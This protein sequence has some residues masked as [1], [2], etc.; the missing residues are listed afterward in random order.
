MP[1]PATYSAIAATFA[2]LSAG[3]NAYIGF[4]N[5]QDALDKQILDRLLKK[6]D[7]CNQLILKNGHRIPYKD[8]EMGDASRIYTIIHLSMRDYEQIKRR[9]PFLQEIPY[10]VKKHTEKEEKFKEFFFNSLHSTIWTDLKNNTTSTKYNDP[11][12]I[13]QFNDAKEFYKKQIEKIALYMALS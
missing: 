10:F 3:I 2:A 8:G 13:S 11:T 9:C 12:L 5:R 1:E 7:E 6:A 4:K